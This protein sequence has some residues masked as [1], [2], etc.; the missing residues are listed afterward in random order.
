MPFGNGSAPL[1]QF[2]IKD[3]VVAATTGVLPF[4]PT[5]SNG[6]SGVGATLTGTV[7]IL[8]FD[9]YTPVIGDR[10]LIKNQASTLQNGIYSVT[11]VGTVIIGY[12]LT[13][14]SDFNS[15][16]NIVYGDT[17][18]VLQGTVNANQQFTMN[19]QNAITVGTTAITFAQT[20][21]GSQLTSGNGIAITG[22]S[23]AIDTAVTVDKTTAQTLTN[24]TLTSPTLTTPSLGVATATSL[25]AS[26]PVTATN[27]VLGAGAPSGTGGVSYGS[28]APIILYIKSVTILTATSPQDIATISIPAGITRYHLLGFLTS[29]GANSPAGAS[30]Y[31][32]AASGT[33]AGASFSIRDAAA[34]AGIN[35]TSGTWSGPSA[36]GVITHSSGVLAGISASL[37]LYLRQLVDSANAG[38]CSFY[39]VILPIP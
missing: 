35:L 23:V 20:S 7:G 12:V 8:A 34:G 33:L 37:T 18:A 15:S 17:V 6:S 30:C 1:D 31:A 32:E 36:A 21:G 22:N 19:N 28:I 4:T 13:R 24:K 5:Y 9:G 2:D 27:G 38:T 14:T 26:G 3:P 16:T 29:V 25:A 39:I 11:T 10:L